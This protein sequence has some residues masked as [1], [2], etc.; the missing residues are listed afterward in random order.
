V[1]DDVDVLVERVRELGAVGVGTVVL[2]PSG[3]ETDPA[4]YLRMTA[5]EVAP[6]VSS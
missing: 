4:G 2:M 1:A 5:T 6:R 3:S